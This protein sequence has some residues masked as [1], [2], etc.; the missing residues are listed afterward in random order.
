MIFATR[1][2]SAVVS[3]AFVIIIAWILTA[4]R[5]CGICKSTSDGV[6]FP[7]RAG[8]VITPAGHSYHSMELTVGS[9]M[10]PDAAADVL[11]YNR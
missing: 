9:V 10:Q 4:V 8:R 5:I 6:V 1:Q 2:Q 11:R 7:T 3:C